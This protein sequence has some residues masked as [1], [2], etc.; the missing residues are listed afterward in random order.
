MAKATAKASKGSNAISSPRKA[1]KASKG[2][3]ST[4][5]PPTP[6]KG[7]QK[8]Q[9]PAQNANPYREHG[10]YWATVEALRAL[11]VGRMHSFDAIVPAVK[12]AFG[13][14]AWKPFASKRGKLT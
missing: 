8:P 10:G 13:P 9:R 7:N 4:R 14:G 2:N 11:G 1:A 12:K 6:Q 3:G 5:K